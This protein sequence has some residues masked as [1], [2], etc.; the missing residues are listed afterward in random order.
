MSLHVTQETLAVLQ[1][2]EGIPSCTAGPW[3]GCTRA[4]VQQGEKQSEDSL[5][6]VPHITVREVAG[7]QQTP[8]LG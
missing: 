7:A 2:S 8:Q 6:S 1:G 4:L 5:L 3:G